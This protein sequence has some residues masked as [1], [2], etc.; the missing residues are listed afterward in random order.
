MATISS[1][2]ADLDFRPVPRRTQ[3]TTTDASEQPP[4]SIVILKKLILNVYIKYDKDKHVETLIGDLNKPYEHLP[5]DADGEH[6]SVLQQYALISTSISIDVSNQSE[7]ITYEP[8]LLIK[9]NDAFGPWNFN[10]LLALL[11]VEYQCDS[12]ERNKFPPVWKT[13]SKTT[14]IINVIK[15]N[16]DEPTKNQNSIKANKKI[17]DTTL[18]G[19]LKTIC[20]YSGRNESHADEWMKAFEGESIATVEQLQ[21][22]IANEKV[23]DAIQTVK[24]IVKQMIRDYVQLNDPSAA[25]NQSN[26]IY[27]DSNATLFGDIHRIRRYFHHVTGTVKHISFLDRR[28]VDEAIIEIRKTYDDD[29]NVLN[30]IHGYLKTFCL[31]TKT[32]DKKAHEKRR[33]GWEEDKDKLVKENEKLI[34]EVAIAEQETK[35]PTTEVEMYRARLINTEKENENAL[36]DR[37]KLIT[38][39]AGLDRCTQAIQWT[40][41]RDQATIKANRAA[42]KV[43]LVKDSLEQAQAKLALLNEPI[44]RK[45]TTI[46]ENQDKIRNLTAFL[47]INGEEAEKKLNVKYGRGLL[48]YGPPGTGKLV[49]FA[50]QN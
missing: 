37:Q 4:P 19:F 17:E 9:K 13:D 43:K 50:F 27:K 14:V 26:D 15:Y 33:E 49:L 34:K 24:F 7:C 18:K 36:G 2:D 45:K 3:Q 38:E 47:N 30:N 29:G 41:K 8:K 31:Q 44:L 5:K 6:L 11:Q 12:S 48:L 40:T 32:M 42:E 21:T 20:R 23:W 1:T 10:P 16:E 25:S 28:A 39:A 22:A 46:A 35:G